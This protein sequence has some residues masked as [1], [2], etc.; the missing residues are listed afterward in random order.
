MIRLPE[1][2]RTQTHVAMA[3]RLYKDIQKGK[4]SFIL[5]WD[6]DDDDYHILAVKLQDQR[7][8]ESLLHWQGN[9]IDADETGNI[10]MVA[11]GG[12]AL[13]GLNGKLAGIASRMM[14][15][16]SFVLFAKQTKTQSGESTR[17]RIEF[18]PP[19]SSAVYL[20]L[21]GEGKR[22]TQIPMYMAETHPHE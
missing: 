12:K 3:H 20:A 19:E 7:K 15:P 22:E 1:S 21:E 17:F 5:K 18:K 14:K 16:G 13:K 11:A 4:V 9:E 10:P 2:F 6:K 8:Q